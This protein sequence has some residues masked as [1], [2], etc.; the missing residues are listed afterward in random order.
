MRIVKLNSRQTDL[1]EVA[2][3]L[4]SAAGF[5]RL[6]NRGDQKGDQDAGD[7]DHRDELNERETAVSV[8]WPTGRFLCDAHSMTNPKNSTNANDAKSM[9][10]DLIAVVYLNPT[11]Q[12]RIRQSMKR[13][14]APDWYNRRQM[15]QRVLS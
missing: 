14:L 9:A 2:L 12:R 13:P 8:G 11:S 15:M 10:T 4:C 5:P 1:A 7:G 3:A 6:L